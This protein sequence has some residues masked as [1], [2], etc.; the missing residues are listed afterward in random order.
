MIYRCDPSLHDGAR[1]GLPSA[2]A[3]ASK[4]AIA[5][6]SWLKSTRTPGCKALKQVR[7]G[8][9][10]PW[11]HEKLTLFT[12]ARLSFETSRKSRGYCPGMA[13]QQYGIFRPKSGLLL[14]CRYPGDSNIV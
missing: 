12:S 4:R 7:N 14:Y 2:G 3:S 10:G 9:S 8:T 1:Q 6:A 5:F 13:R 11:H